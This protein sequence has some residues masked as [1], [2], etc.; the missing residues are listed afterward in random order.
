MNKNN[1]IG[2]Y[3]IFVTLVVSVVGINIFTQPSEMAKT[4]G[5]DGWMVS[6][7]VGVISFIVLTIIYKVSSA[8]NYESLYNILVRNTGVF[9][10][11]I[12]GILYILFIILS[13]AVGM[14]IFSEVLKMYLLE[15]TPTE[16]IIV[17]ML[18][19]GTY[20][21]RG[22]ISSLIKVNEVSFWVMFIPIYLVLLFAFSN[23][24][25]TNIFPILQ[26]KPMNYVNAIII[27]SYSFGGLEIA[28]LII[29]FMKEKTKFMVFSAYA[30]GFIALFYVIINLF[31]IAT[32]SKYETSSLIWPTITMVKSINIPGGFIE[33]L[34]GSIMALWVLFY[35]ANF[36]NSFFFASDLVKDVFALDD[37]KLSSLVVL[38]I[39]YIVALYPESIGELYKI[40]EKIFPL[41]I[42]LFLLLIPLILLIITKA[43]RV[44]EN[45]NEV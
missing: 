37:I 40:S 19:C 34:E 33:G 24:D 11:K 1:F 32:F 39:I 20:L 25:F 28:F 43:K 6:I 3:G 42:A 10:G 31:C 27:S 7:L 16:F 38:P 21:I 8:N 23:A 5:N 14:R 22:D 2:G 26:N 9:L 45:E 36:T 15:K 4:V 18:I 13:I 29:P 44:G 12:I 17:T 30:I 41:I 35:F